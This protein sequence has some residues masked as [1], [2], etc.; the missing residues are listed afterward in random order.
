MYFFVT[1]LFLLQF[2]LF[3]HYFGTLHHI[4]LVETAFRISDWNRGRY[5]NITTNVFN[6]WLAQEAIISCNT[7]AFI[8][9]IACH[10]IILSGDCIARWCQ[11]MGI[12]SRCGGDQLPGHKRLQGAWTRTLGQCVI[13]N[14]RLLGVVRW[15]FL[16]RTCWIGFQRW[17]VLQLGVC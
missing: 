16:W 15:M 7:N 17:N 4:F 3:C 6:V 1:V 14:W 12:G 13:P 2:Y 8:F 11:D 10:V 5:W 9:P